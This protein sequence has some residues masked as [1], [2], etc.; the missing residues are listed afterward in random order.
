MK[1]NAVTLT[2]FLLQVS[3]IGLFV[4]I[5]VKDCSE[6]IDLISK[7]IVLLR[8]LNKLHLM[9]KFQMNQNSIYIKVLD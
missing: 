7:V 6:L 5:E 9:M 8:S 4:V 2:C 1:V 3:I